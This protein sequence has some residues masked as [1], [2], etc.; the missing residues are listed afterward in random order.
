[1]FEPVHGSAPDIAGQGI[2]NPI[3]QIW[4]GAMM[5]EHL[6]EAE[7]AQAVVTAFE[8]VLKNGG[9]RTRDLGGTAT[10]KEVGEAIVSSPQ[11]DAVSFT[12][13]VA[14]GRA[15]LVGT[16]ARQAKVQLEM[17][18]KNP[19]VV[20]DDADLDIAVDCAINGAFYSTGQRCTASSRR[21]C[22]PPRRTGTGW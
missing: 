8:D 22:A 21:T 9:P 7:A 10:T 15:V 3:A 20:L 17:G 1:M 14:T 5:L 4:S 19:L 2:A 18:G 16:A 11:V 12:G 6:G 13:S